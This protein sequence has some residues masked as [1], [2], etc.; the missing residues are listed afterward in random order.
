MIG[1]VPAGD[2]LVL[3]RPALDLAARLGKRLLAPVL[4][5]SK[6]L[7]LQLQ[8][9]FSRVFDAPATDAERRLRHWPVAGALWIG[10]I[11]VLLLAVLAGLD[12]LGQVSTKG[13]A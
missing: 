6:R 11:A 12:H 10:I 1:L 2:L 7:S 4:T 3:A 9:H 5:V 8:G 13:A